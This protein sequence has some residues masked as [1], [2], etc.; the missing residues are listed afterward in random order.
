MSMVFSFFI[1]GLFFFEY[2]KKMILGLNTNKDPY[3]LYLLLIFFSVFFI[4]IFIVSF[5]KSIDDIYYKYNIFIKENL[6]QLLKLIKSEDNFDEYIRVL[7]SNKKGEETKFNKEYGVYYTPREIVHYMC[8]KSLLYYLETELNGKITK[9]DLEK[10]VNYAENMEFEKTAIE[11]EEK[12][13]IGEQKTTKYESQIPESI[14]KNAKEIDDLLANI[15]VCDPAVGSGAFPIGMLHEIVRLRKLLSIYLDRK[16]T[17]YNLKRHCIENSLYGVDIDAGAIEVCKLRFWLSMIVDEEDFY[18]IKPLPNLDYKVVHGDSLLG[19]KENLYNKEA[20]FKLENFKIQYFNETNPSNKEELKNKIDH[21]ID[22]ITEG[23]RNFDFKV[24]FSEV[25]HHKGG[26][27][28]VIGNPPYVSTKGV[29]ES[30]K[31]LLEQHYQFADDLYNHFY[32]KGLNICRTNGILIFISSISIIQK[33]ISDNQNQITFLDG[34]KNFANPEE[35]V[36]DQ[37][38]YATAPNIVFFKPTSYNMKI[39]EKLGKKVNELLNKWW[40]K[41]S[42]SKNIEKNKKELEKYRNTLKEGDITL[43]GLI[44]EGGVGIQ[45]G[46]NGKYIGVLE[47]TKWAD[48][49]RKER[50]EKLL[51]A[52][53]FCI[54]KGI[55]TKKDA[56]KFLENLIEQE[57]GELFDNLKKQYGR[58]IFGQG[59]LYR[60]VSKDEIADVDKITEDEKLNGIVGDK[61]FVPYDKGDKEGNRWYAP[62]PYYIDWSRKNVKILQTDPKARWQGYQFYFREGFCWNNVTGNKIICRIK[63]KSVH[64]TEAMTFISLLPTKVSNSYLVCLMNSKFFGIYKN[65]FLNVT[66]HLT[67]GDAK[68]FPIIIPTKDQLKQFEDIFNRAYEIQKNKFEGKISEEEAD[69]KLQEVQEILDI[70]VEQMYM[71]D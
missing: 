28:V 69:G 39:Y 48:K 16:E 67:T 38:V 33:K 30:Y 1:V 4:F 35:Y 29:P 61:T 34:S 25:F 66:V 62:T 15:R 19:I 71:G 7:K 6:P 65:I 12:I 47:D 64:S 3:I 40:D 27:D 14:K 54:K 8:R 17:T 57:I 20:L 37:Q 46:D 21:L 22:K 10:F 32:F 5:E 58:D 55:K 36:I 41:I 13:K 56:E 42:T 45:T 51:L 63:E 9:G 2:L 11:K 60:I 24:Y 18:Q 68:E 26:F 50:P 49:V 53:D 31:K 52:T 23:N 70:L 59:W 44:T 43:L